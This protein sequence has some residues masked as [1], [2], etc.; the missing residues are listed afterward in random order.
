M[1]PTDAPRKAR[2]LVVDDHPLYRQGVIQLINR[3]R[4]V[5]CCGEAATAADT[6]RAVASSKPDLAILDVRLGQEDGLELIKVLRAQFPAVRIL[7]LSSYEEEIYA[8]RALRAGAKG[9]LMKEEATEQVLVAVR[10]ILNGELY[11]SRKLNV[12]FLDKLLKAP[13]RTGGQ[14][15]DSLTDRELQVF[16]LLGAGLSTRQIAAKLNLSFKTIETH[17]ENIKHRLGLTNAE[18]LVRAATAWVQG[19]EKISF[20]LVLSRRAAS[21]AVEPEQSFPRPSPRR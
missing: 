21:R 5:A 7:V 8:E 6:C 17:R 13:A 3:Q 20:D 19:K 18:E 1:K 4:D 14:P 9:Y 16:Q 10:A 11:V 12:L 2:V 15:I